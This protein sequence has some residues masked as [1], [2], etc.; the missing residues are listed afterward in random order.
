VRP[1]WSRLSFRQNSSGDLSPGRRIG[2]SQSSQ[3]PIA[4]TRRQIEDAA[5]HGEPDN[6]PRAVENGCAMAAN[7]KMVFKSKPKIDAEVP[8]NILGN[9]PMY[10]PT[11]DLN[12][13]KI[14]ASGP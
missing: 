12:K 8:V 5:T 6:V 14:P 7:T 10:C 4:E 1:K 11:T 13:Q 2:L 3:E 9:K